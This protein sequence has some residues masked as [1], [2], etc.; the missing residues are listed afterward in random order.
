[1]SAPAA[2]A[3]SEPVMT[4]QPTPGS[5]SNASTA[6]TTSDSIALLSALSALGRW[7]VTTATRPVCSTR[8]FSNCFSVTDMA[9]SS[10]GRACDRITYLD[11][12][13]FCPDA[14]RSPCERSPVPQPRPYGLAVLD[15]RGLR[16]RHQGGVPHERSP[17]PVPVVLE[18]GGHR[19]AL[20][21]ELD[22]AERTA[23]V[24]ALPRGGGADGEATVRQDPV[25]GELVDA[26]VLLE[27]AQAGH[28]ERHGPV[29]Q[30][31]TTVADQLLHGDELRHARRGEG[32]PARGIGVVVGD[33]QAHRGDVVRH[34]VE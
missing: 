6:S 34:G 23:T 25:L 14:S 10:S 24:P 29:R 11:F 27:R 21:E 8:M 1:M 31:W 13:G 33:H 7:S 5:E 20:L 17:V 19:L 32:D 26:G 12:L 2:K 22:E 4:M 30:H 9:C 28:V 3:F 15:R 16:F 18:I